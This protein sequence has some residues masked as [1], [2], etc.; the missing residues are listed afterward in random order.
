MNLYELSQNYLAVQDMDLEPETLKDTLD[1]IE[2]AIEVK[3]ENI[4]KWIRNLEADKKA[5]EEEE[6][7]FKDKKQA[8]DNRIKSL[9]LYLEDNMR[10]TGKTKF[11]AGFFSFAIQNNPPSVEVFDEAL[12]PKQFLIAQPVKI[13][14][15]GIKELLKAGEEVPGAELKHS[16]SLRIR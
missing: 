8:A 15:A 6:K 7:R 9:K 16:S 4:A 11:K 10:L 12:I 5:F 14:R 1:S 2:E 13:D 3:A